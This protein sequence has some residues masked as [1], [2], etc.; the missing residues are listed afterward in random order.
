MNTRLFLAAI[1]GAVVSF[2]LGWL[3]YGIILSDFMQANS[4]HYDGLKTE[5]PNFFLL[6]LSGLFMSFF[7]AFVFQRWAGFTTFMNGVFGGVII[8]F[9]IAASVD[10]SFFSMMNLFTPYY[11]FADIV[12]GTVITGIEGGVIAAI[13]GYRKKETAQG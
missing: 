12:V 6:I 13:L 7:I 1:A 2:L 10:L 9:F 3:V 5:M 8:G 11:L 4:I